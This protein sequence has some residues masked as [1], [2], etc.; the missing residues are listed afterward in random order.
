MTRK[1]SEMAR[2]E[3]TDRV[4]REAMDKIDNEMRAR[5]GDK[6][7]DNLKRITEQRDAFKTDLTNAIESG[8]SG[9][10]MAEFLNG[11]AWLWM[12]VYEDVE[13]DPEFKAKVE[14][15][16]PPAPA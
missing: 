2:Q 14:H 13:R 16:P 4:V 3:E 8:K 10:L 12:Y 15:E 11:K 1:T 7:V 6:F 9:P 5:F